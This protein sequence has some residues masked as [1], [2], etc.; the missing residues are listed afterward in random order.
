M[1]QKSIIFK[2][3]NIS[4]TDQGKGKVVVFLHG[5]LAAKEVWKSFATALSKSQRVITIDLLGHGKTECLSYVHTMEEMAEAVEAVI[6]HLKLRK[7]FLVGHSLG[8]YVSLA[9]AENNPDNLKGLVLF[10]SSAKADSVQRKKDRQRVANIV[11][12][13]A[14]LFI[15][16][17]IPYLFNT[18]VK[19]YKRAIAKLNKLANATSVQGIVAALEGMKIRLDR[20]IVLKF[21]PYPIL[22]IIG[23]ADT[24]FPYEDLVLQAKLTENG[25]Y[26]LL[27]S[28]GHMGFEEAE[29][30]TYQAIKK[31]VVNN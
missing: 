2:S 12:K 4:F 15:H 5:F 19:P 20:E 1:K 24:I 31:F 29:E 27:D 14:A 26:M 3:I 13:N 28:V 30:E 10:H 22:F 11:K 8:G 21:S 17:A 18:K 23:K 25:T 16:E 9:M 7:Y 6:I